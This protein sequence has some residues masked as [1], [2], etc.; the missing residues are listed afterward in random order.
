M[1]FESTVAHNPLN[2][3]HI[4]DDE[5]CLLISEVG[6]TF[7]GVNM[8]VAINSMLSFNFSNLCN[9]RALNLR[10]GYIELSTG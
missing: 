2:L 10:F 4:S 1:G 5:G 7:L 3:V 9:N 8:L 6:L